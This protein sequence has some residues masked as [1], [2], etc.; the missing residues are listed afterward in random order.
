MNPVRQLAEQHALSVISDP[1]NDPV[2]LLEALLLLDV[3]SPAALNSVL[4]SLSRKQRLAWITAIAS[5]VRQMPQAAV[6]IVYR[7]FLLT[8]PDRDGA[9]HYT[10]LLESERITPGDMAHLLAVRRPLSL[11]RYAPVA[12]FFHLFGFLRVKIRAGSLRPAHAPTG[13]FNTVSG[14]ASISAAG[15]KSKKNQQSPDDRN[16]DGM[17]YD[18]E[19]P[20][21]AIVI[22]RAGTGF[23]GGAERLA[24]EYARYLSEIASVEIV[25]TQA[26]DYLTWKNEFPEGLQNENGI[27]LRRFPVKNR[28]HRLFYK[29]SML[30]FRLLSMILSAGSPPS[31]LQKRPLACIFWKTL[32]PLA[33]LW[34]RL[35]GPHSPG[36]QAWIKRLHY[37]FYIFVTYL[38]ETSYASLPIVADRAALVPTAHPEWPLQLPIWQRIFHDRRPGWIFLAGEE[39]RF[40]RQWFPAMND[41]PV[42]GCGLASVEQLQALEQK[43]AAGL[44]SFRERF[45]INGPF[46]LY[47]GRID[48]EKGCRKLIAYF[49]A[50]LRKSSARITL[51]LIGTE[52]MTVPAHPAI[53]TTG[54]VDDEVMHAALCECSVYVHPSPYESFSFSLL[55]AM[56]AGAPVLV[57]A[58]SDV[59]R[60]HVIRSRAGLYYRDVD[61]FIEKLTVLLREPQRFQNGPHYVQERYSHEAVKGTLQRYVLERICTQHRLQ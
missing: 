12:F 58:E 49:L 3:S 20:S 40:L 30:L 6:E 2:S 19:R 33:I 7:V 4:R 54:F 61:D 26:R 13:D 8:Y 51:V 60:G 50:F 21:I 48:P 10:S 57:T 23:S 53:V 16:T 27:L 15:Q 31:S 36:L 24:F 44:S 18:S 32:T 52:A 5:C 47:T 17:D 35:Q 59:L 14:V 34:M 28:R 42:V 22:H 38:Y 39:R 46:V 43:R 55:E 9:R 11:L 25:T 41:G 29:L 56:A 1:P 45:S 37:D